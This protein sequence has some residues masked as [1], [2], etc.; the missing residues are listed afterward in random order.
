MKISILKKNSHVETLGHFN[1]P[2]LDLYNPNKILKIYLCFVFL[3]I[4]IYINI[5]SVCIDIENKVI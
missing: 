2:H 3:F 1:L 4:S 5:Y